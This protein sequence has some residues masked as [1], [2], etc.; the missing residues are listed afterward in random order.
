MKRAP[1]LRSARVRACRTYDEA[2]EATLDEVL[3]TT[4]RSCSG[5]THVT[6]SWNEHDAEHGLPM[7]RQRHECLHCSDAYD[8][9]HQVP[10][11]AQYR[12]HLWD[13]LTVGARLMTSVSVQV[14]RAVKA[15][16]LT[17]AR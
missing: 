3:D 13:A 7:L 16:G 8:R 17:T 10:L 15:I 9:I 5:T 6:E 12:N 11:E 2:L 4:C 1:D 14:K